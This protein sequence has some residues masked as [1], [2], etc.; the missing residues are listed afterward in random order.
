MDESEFPASRYR[1][2]TDVTLPK[3]PVWER[4]SAEQR[5]AISVVAKVLP[6]RTNA[7]VVEQL[8]DWSR[9]PQDPIFQMTFVQR[10]MLPSEGYER[11]RRLLQRKAPDSEIRQEV[12]AIRRSL[13]PHPDGQITH[14]VPHLDG[15]PLP[16]LQ[17]KYRETVLFFPGQGQTCHAYCTYCF[18]WA[19]FVDL[20]DMRFQSWETDDLLAYLR[21][22]PDVTDVLVTGG[23]P[24]IMKTSVLRRYIEP[25][26]R[27]EMA[28]IRHLRIGSKAL[29]YWP[30]RFVSDDDADDLLRLFESVVAAGKHLALMA[31]F[32]HPV[33]LSPAVAREAVRR[34][35]ATGAEIRLQAPIIRHVNDRPEVWAELWRAAV[36]LGVHPYYTFVERD[37]GPRQYFEVPLARC[38]E[39]FRQAYQQVSGLARS[40]R[41]P[42]MSALPGKVRLLGVREVAG[43]PC[44]VLDFLQ[45][46]DASWVK[47]PFFAKFDAEATWFDAL[48]PAFEDDRP[49]F[50]PPILEHASAVDEAVETE[51]ST[52][53][54]RRRR[55]TEPPTPPALSPTK[56]RLAKRSAAAPLTVIKVGGS[57]LESPDD[58]RRAASAI[59][60]RHR[61]SGALVVVV[62][63]LKGITDLLERAVVQAHDRRNGNGYLEATLTELRRRHAAVA[64]TL[65]AGSGAVLTEIERH[66]GEVESLLAVCRD[67]GRLPDPAYARLLSAGERMSV[68]L[69][70]AAVE[71]QG[72]RASA[73]NAEAIELR[74]LGSPRAGVCD[75]AASGEA[76]RRLR[77]RAR[78]GV[79]ILTGFYAIDPHGNTVLFGRGGSDDTACAVAAG[80]EAERLELWKDVPGCM[81][82]DPREIREA[83]VIDE[84]SF[85]EVAQLGAYGSRV[86]NPGGLE[87]LRG[88]DTSVFVSPIEGLRAGTGTRLR[89]ILHRDG[90]AVVALVG[91][92][93]YNRVR[94]ECP[95][96][97]ELR[98]I[99]S[100][101]LAALLDARIT[102]SQFSLEPLSI[103]FCVSDA[104]VSRVKQALREHIN[105]YEV[106]IRRRPPLVAAIGDGVADS[107]PIRRSIVE[108]LAASHV[109]SDLVAQ[110]AWSSGVSFSVHPD[111]LAPALR[112]LHQHYFA[113]EKAAEEPAGPAAESTTETRATA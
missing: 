34:V 38:Y 46:R 67:R 106:A 66:L 93:G 102:L 59:A 4:L 51:I 21:V 84:I 91:Q 90:P 81:S 28:H 87:P 96:E 41:G 15:R 69:V 18:R 64:E 83:R 63:A 112:A 75:I 12:N 60:S 97:R 103:S 73:L 6:F 113:D 17:H 89:E 48:E 8:I 2:I 25:L 35:R 16:G 107:E 108:I 11:V 14:N 56:L 109:R 30:Q 50:R 1:P 76:F 72:E 39:I 110:P 3:S 101:I 80:L 36:R 22:H 40:A 98:E 82:A 88:R 53:E 47:R 55:G 20:P 100:R 23:D 33:E 111:D 85:Q 65:T 79:V 92:R 24:L 95:S 99:A 44:F 71:A 94:L 27:P 5:E 58:L 10:E 9:V 32:S 86:V 45:A 49:F 105:G 7:Y 74:A 37:T 31:H 29:S 104:E 78:E 52:S 77:K 26:L 68:L 42:V 62:S 19:Q 57:L 13:N 43:Q 54:R 61:T 70:S